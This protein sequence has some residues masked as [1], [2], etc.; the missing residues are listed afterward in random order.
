MLQPKAYPEMVGKALVLEPE[1]F[2][3]MVEDDNPWVEGLF[4]VTC[5]GLLMGVADLVGGLLFTASM[6]SFD[7]VRET[8]QRALVNFVPWDT[9]LRYA[10]LPTWATSWLAGMAGYG[11][12]WTRFYFALWVPIAL[13]FQWFFLG[14]STHVAA[15]ALGGRGSLVQTLGTTALAAAPQLLGV[16]KVVPFVSVSGVLLGV[17]ALLIAYRAVAITHDLP[18]QRAALAALAAPLVLLVLAFGIAAIIGL[19]LLAG[20]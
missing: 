3:T 11:D 14:I 9:Q 4:L 10:A 5:V 20:G 15:R 16:L 18:W 6:P 17:W 19:A 8:L 2:L 7:A 13:I 12:G 1:P